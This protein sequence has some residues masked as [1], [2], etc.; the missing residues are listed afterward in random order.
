M[1]NKL[2]KYGNFYT[3]Q[4]LDKNSIF[5]V[6]IQK[7]IIVDTWN[8]LFQSSNESYFFYL[9]MCLN[10]IKKIMITIQLINWI[11]E[12]KIVLNY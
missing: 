9:E 4:T 5:I 3:K 10:N 6:L 11:S 8:V 7:Q 1:K 12:T 2:R